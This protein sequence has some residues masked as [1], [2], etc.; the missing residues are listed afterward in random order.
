MTVLVTGATGFSGSALIRHLARTGEREI[1]GLARGQLA[2]LSQP[3]DVRFVQCDLTDAGQAL[4]VVKMTLP[5]RIIHLAG[6]SRGEPHEL[7]RANIMGTENLLAAVLETVPEC[8]VMVV[9]SSAVYGYAGRGPITED[10]PL[11]SR[12]DYGASKVAQEQVALERHAEQGALVAIARPFN[13][14]G[15]GQPD[16]FLCG[17]I[18]RQAVEIGQGVR[19]RLDLLETRSYRDFIDVRDA[20]RAYAAL[21]SRPDFAKACAGRAFNIGSGKAHAVSDVIVLLEE[22]TG[23][24]YVVD[25]PEN[26]PV[27]P[28][29]FQ[30]A[31]I[32]RITGLTGWL[33]EI[34]LKES[35][36]DMLAAAST[37]LKNA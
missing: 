11:K 30:Q 34:P 36:S 37:G 9:S 32:A 33:P 20:V 22:I 8:R 17:R 3:A 18:V 21:V 14:V 10:A 28:V 29:P 23:K 6:L 15:P 25:L 7:F 2:V 24:T 13:L 1:V 16:L 35:L 27:I 12:G 26:P 19:D 4:T 5:D 31:D